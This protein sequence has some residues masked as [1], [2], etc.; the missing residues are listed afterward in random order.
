[1]NLS[2]LNFLEVVPSRTL[3]GLYIILDI[4]FLLFFLCLLFFNKR[5]MTFIFAII[6]GIIYFIVDYGIFYKL[7]GTRT[8][9]NASPFWFLL[10]LSMSYGI[11]NFAWIWLWIKKDKRL[12]E[13]SVLILTWWIACPL[14][15]Q[16]FGSTENMISISRGT[17]SYHGV[18][19]LIMFVGYA[20]LC[21]Y[22]IT[23]ANDDKKI[24]IVWL[25]VIGI[26]VQFGWEFSLY[27]TGIRPQDS[28]LPM[29]VDS[30]IETNL[31]IPFIFMIYK[32]V[33]KRYN[34]DLSLVID[35]N[36]VL[37]EANV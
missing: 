16:N 35:S 13:W 24:N 12:L 4:I 28:L 6:G 19:A 36:K 30:L 8:V 37:E 23:I 1:M 22:N 2:L 15:S 14:L 27:I 9:N 25:L 10:W 7:L 17:N 32:A 5:I 34:E 29:I 3:N 20:I 31:G 21:I 26:L 11:T 18:M 33:S